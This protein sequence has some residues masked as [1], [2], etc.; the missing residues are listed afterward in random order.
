MVI[1]SKGKLKEQLP[2]V[3]ETIAIMN[4]NR[5]RKPRNRAT[6]KDKGEKK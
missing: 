1:K 5:A 3:E 2:T 6:V 4:R